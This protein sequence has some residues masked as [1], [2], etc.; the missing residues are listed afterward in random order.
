MWEGV[1]HFRCR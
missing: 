1:M